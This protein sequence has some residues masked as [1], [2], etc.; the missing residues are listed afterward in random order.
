MKYIIAIWGLFTLIPITCSGQI[1]ITDKIK[2]DICY[3]AFG[4][5]IGEEYV[6]P[7]GSYEKGRVYPT[8]LVTVRSLITNQFWED[9]E[10]F[11]TMPYDIL[12][13]NSLDSHDHIFLVMG[14]D[15]IYFN[16]YDKYTVVI[17]RLFRILKKYKVD[18][19]LFPLFCERLSYAYMTAG[20]QKDFQMSEIEKLYIGYYLL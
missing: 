17:R 11:E 10:I 8:D 18:K 1:V 4:T 16:I 2:Y 3:K 20:N 9:S 6:L 14:K 19:L 15:I 5:E 13:V 12:N 7:D